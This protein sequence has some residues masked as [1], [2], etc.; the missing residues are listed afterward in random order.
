M[1][2]G[3]EE[4]REERY[5]IRRVQLIDGVEYPVS[6]HAP[7]HSYIRFSPDPIKRTYKGVSALNPFSESRPFY[8]ELYQD[9]LQ[10]YFKSG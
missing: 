5:P 9:P 10:T 1:G 6:T 3:S 8:L 2:Q 7:T 4:G